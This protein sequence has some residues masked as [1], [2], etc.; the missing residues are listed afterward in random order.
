M[1]I[2]L[3]PRP[4]QNQ[5]LTDTPSSRP[6]K[7]HECEACQDRGYRGWKTPTAGYPLKECQV[8]DCRIGVAVAAYW[9]RKETAAQQLRLNRLFAGAGIPTRFQNL[10]VE[11]LR[12]RAGDDPE[13][14][15]AFAAVQQFIDEGVV[16]CPITHRYK[17]GLIISGEWGI[18]KTGIITAALRVALEKG[19]SGL[20]IEMYEFLG[21]IQKGYDTH[22]SD[23]KLEAAQKADIILIDDLGDVERTKPESDDRRKLLYELINYR[24]NY[25]L[26]MLITTNC[27]AELI[28]RQLG[29]R[30]M[31]RIFESCAWIQMGGRN[32]RME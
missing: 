31:E 21:A 19:K 22:D 26:P 7:P 27:D 10:T 6:A 25:D 16:L 23:A 20:W 1:D 12:E 18:G 32:L 2:T 8:C 3:P 17:A 28:A 9:Q 5:P 14:Q 13:K 29:T 4:Q 15:A 11:T 24:H 30:T